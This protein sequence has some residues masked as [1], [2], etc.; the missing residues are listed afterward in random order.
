MIK[1]NGSVSNLSE[2][3]AWVNELKKSLAFYNFHA[4]PGYNFKLFF[5]GVSDQNYENCPSIYRNHGLIVNEHILLK[6]CIARV[7]TN[8]LMKK[9]H[10]IS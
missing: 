4:S 1:T 7:L 8:L 9:Q 3:I 5:R 6:E 10:L 2:F